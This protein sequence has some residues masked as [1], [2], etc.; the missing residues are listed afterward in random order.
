MGTYVVEVSMYVLLHMYCTKEM[1]LASKA[2]GG[3]GPERPAKVV[4]WRGY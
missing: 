3:E 4:A 2:K 1:R